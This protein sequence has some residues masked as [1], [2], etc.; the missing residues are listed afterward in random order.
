MIYERNRKFEDV[1]SKFIEEKSRLTDE[2]NQLKETNIKLEADKQEQLQKT[3]A[4]K[5]INDSQVEK[6]R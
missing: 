5:L 3:A 1:Q 4:Q 6:I 2:I